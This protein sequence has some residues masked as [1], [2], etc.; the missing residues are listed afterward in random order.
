MSPKLFTL[1]LEDMFKELN[2]EGKGINLNGEYLN[3]LK[4]ADNRA[5]ISNN[6][7]NEIINTMQVTQRV[8]DSKMFGIILRYW[9]S[10]EEIV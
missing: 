5:V 6:K 1:V 7:L 9:I 2:W 8:I 3:H 10:N 4:F